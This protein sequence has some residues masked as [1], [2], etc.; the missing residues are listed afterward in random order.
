MTEWSIYAGIVGSIFGM[1]FAAIL[2]FMEL[3]L[4]IG[5]INSLFID[6]ILM[7]LWTIFFST[8]LNGLYQKFDRKL[9]FAAGIIGSI[10][11]GIIMVPGLL[12]YLFSG[13]TTSIMPYIESMI[14]TLTVIGYGSVCIFLLLTGIT[15]LIVGNDTER[16]TIIMITGLFSIITGIFIW[17]LIGL[18]MAIPTNILFSISLYT[19]SKTQTSWVV[20]PR[21]KGLELK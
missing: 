11:G 12:S 10:S 21:K 17:G 3:L 2:V 13:L 6:E 8:G 4:G 16:Q 15:F 18:F 9:F 19:L 1:I 14:L 5:I 20:E 7:T